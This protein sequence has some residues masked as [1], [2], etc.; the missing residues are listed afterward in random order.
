MLYNAYYYNYAIL[1]SEK[2]KK[3]VFSFPGFTRKLEL[4]AVILFSQLTQFGESQNI[5]VNTF[6]NKIFSY[7]KNDI[8]DENIINDIKNNNDYQIIFTGHSLGGAISTLAS[9]YF[10]KHKLS[11]NE[12]ILITFGQPRVG[13][14]DF[15][16]DYM[17]INKNVYR[18]Q[19]DE[20]IFSMFPP[21]KKF[22]E[23][24]IIDQ[25]K[26]ISGIISTLENVK[27]LKI[28]Y[29]LYSSLSPAKVVIKKITEIAIKKIID[30][31]VETIKVFLEE[32][33]FSEIYKLIPYGYFPYWRALCDKS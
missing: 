3:Y 30:E 8:F 21:I 24:M 25:I 10:S 29:D 33:I 4:I 26:K 7:I 20:D 9:Y 11:K 13:N 1:K 16:K 12:I 6:F 28:I 32:Y 18:I 17:S 27:I 15:A 31:I 23:K 14:E 5:K 2:Y 22:S 19:R